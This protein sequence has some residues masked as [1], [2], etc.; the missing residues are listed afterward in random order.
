MSDD[1]LISTICSKKEDIL[2]SHFQCDDALEESGIIGQQPD[3]ADHT[4]NRLHC[5]QGNKLS[6]PKSKG[7]HDVGQDAE[8]EAPEQD[9]APHLEQQLRLHSNADSAG[10]CQKSLLPSHGI[11]LL[12][13]PCIY[14]IGAVA[15]PNICMSRV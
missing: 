7:N 5:N 14:K 6:P 13:S 10:V 3:F 2:F 11:V 15:L 4:I 12:C 8:P 1:A 9:E